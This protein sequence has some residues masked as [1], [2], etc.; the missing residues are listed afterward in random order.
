[1][2]SNRWPWR[3]LIAHSQ[4]F[5]GTIAGEST[6]SVLDAV[7]AGGKVVDSKKLQPSITVRSLSAQAMCAGIRIQLF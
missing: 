5:K 1:M 4:A 6:S 2:P 3:K 7:Q